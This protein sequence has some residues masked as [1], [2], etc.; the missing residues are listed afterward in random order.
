MSVK[1]KPFK[2]FF[3]DPLTVNALKNVSNEPDFS[4]CR[5][6]EAFFVHYRGSTIITS[7]RAAKTSFS[8]VNHGVPT[9]TTSQSVGVYRRSYKGAEEYGNQ[10]HSQHHIPL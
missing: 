4:D 8:S 5:R 3:P 10:P 9:P 6:M 2:H 7:T 1:F